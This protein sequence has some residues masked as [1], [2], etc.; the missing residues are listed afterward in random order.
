MM[1]DLFLKM[2]QKVVSWTLKY[3]LLGT[4]NVTPRLTEFQLEEII[5]LCGVFYYKEWD[6]EFQTDSPVLNTIAWSWL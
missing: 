5:C 6:E 4:R 3:W 1:F 2:C